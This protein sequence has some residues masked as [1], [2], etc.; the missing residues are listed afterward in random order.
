MVP[1]TRYA[2]SGNLHI[3]YQVVGDGP[4][5]LV[6]VHG[7]ISHIEHLWEEPS[8][9]RFLTRLAS[10]SRLILLDKR[11]RVSPILSH[12]TSYPHSKKGWMTYAL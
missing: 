10:F 8:L 2:R 1:E 9:A 4:V 6:F 5:D 7:W 12:S 3:A 11:G